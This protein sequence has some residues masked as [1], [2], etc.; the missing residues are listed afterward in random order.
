[1]IGSKKKIKTVFDS[2]R[3]EG[4]PEEQIARCHSPI[5][6]EIGAESPAEIALAIAAEIVAHFNKD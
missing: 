2:L 1:M 4:V 6:L 5:G 3:A